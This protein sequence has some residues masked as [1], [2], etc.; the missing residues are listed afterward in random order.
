MPGSLAFV[1]HSHLPWLRQHGV[2][3][4]GE[5]WLFQSWSESYL[6]LIRVLDG[7]ADDG[8]TDVVTLGITPVLAEQMADPYLMEEF[9]GW[10]GRRQ[11]DLRWTMSAAPASDKAT[12]GPV[13]EHH[14]QRQA[15]LLE[16]LEGGLLDTGLVEP[17]ARLAR[18]GVIQLLGG[19]ATHPYLPLM[20][21]PALIRGQ[22][23]D[24]LAITQSLTGI[25]PTGVWTPECGYRPAGRVADP[26][27]IPLHVA[28]DG[29]PTLPVSTT[30]L[31]GIEAFWAEAGVSHLVLDGP[32]LARAAGAPP[33][34]W[35]S[36]ARDLPRV[37]TPMDV[38]DRPV[39]IGD[40][41]VA[42]FGRNLAVA[43]AVWNPTGGY[44]AD[45]WYRD[46]H[47][48]DMEG[49]YKS[50]RVTDTTSLI[51]EPYDPA[52]ATAR[53]ADHA[54]DFIGLLS[55]HI[56]P[57]PDDTCVV[58]A[59]DTELFGHWW[60]EGPQWLDAVVRGLAAQADV[61][62]TTLASSLRQHPP[63][64]SLALPESSWGWGKGH[65][66]W[67]TEETRWIWREIRRA[68][69][70][71]SMLPG[72]PS[73]RAAWRQLT[74]LQASDWPFMIAREQSAQYA[75]ERVKTHLARFEQACRGTL[76]PD[77]DLAAAHTPP[78][79]HTRPA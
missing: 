6:P 58:A 41:D 21:D 74:L 17:F 16:Q 29:T 15:Q 35:G 13:W 79:S 46:F 48:I 30:D 25:R 45:V 63:S 55:E 22:I 78:A 67:V 4:V 43:Y 65:A 11:L 14:W 59:Y 53:V 38:L 36:T 42:A 70:R 26:S 33:T 20:T 24:G 47:A 2:F 5:E 28:D 44:P 75:V 10:L 23:A 1:L 51:K 12:L 64:T 40:S 3:P 52:A 73:R 76:D 32:T 34:D 66:A 18:R 37:G 7:L 60:Y 62:T 71:F 19:P 8:F 56:A 50:W 39:L 69:E 77:T 27:E 9:H 31:P 68:E 54:A 57:R 61:G 49:G 72:G